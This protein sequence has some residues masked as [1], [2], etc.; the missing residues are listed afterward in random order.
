[1]GRLAGSDTG[2]SQLSCRC[3]ITV[4]VTAVSRLVPDP[5]TFGNRMRVA[6]APDP[7]LRHD[8]ADGSKSSRWLR[9][10]AGPYQNSSLC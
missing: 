7:I 4:A 3:T 2:A 10:L 1:M 8:M 5:T 9:A 6:P